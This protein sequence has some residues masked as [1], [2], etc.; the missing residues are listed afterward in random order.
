M[1]TQTEQPAVAVQP[2]PAAERPERS[3]RNLG[4]YLIPLVA[5]AGLIGL[6]E[7]VVVLF[8]IPSYI[9]PSP[10]EVWNTMVSDWG[11]LMA[12]LVPT[13]LETALGFVLGNGVAI[14]LAVVFVHSKPV[15]RAF[16]PV[17]IFIRTIPIVAIAPVLVIMFGTGYTPKVLIAALI[18]FFP[19]LVN[20]VRGLESVD[21][22]ALELMRVLSATRREVL[23]KVRIFASLPYV[24]SALKIAATSAV[25]GA[26]VAEWIGSD[27]GLG[28]MIVQ[29]TY[30]YR[31]AELYA[32][33]V[34][35]SLFASVCF[36]VVGLAERLVVRWDT[37][38]KP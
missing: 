28:Y 11:T 21:T 10:V 32:A 30:N 22:Q 17:A 33:M 29:A 35:T 15:E 3:N 8:R 1:V 7:A 9:V 6:W 4:R 12:N 19:T 13:A 37:E 18:S 23:F 27:S 2:S 25:I 36:A 14:V 20:T 16:F 34:V 31:T 26:V 24:F 38:A 5:I